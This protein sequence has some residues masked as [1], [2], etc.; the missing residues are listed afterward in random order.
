[1]APDALPDPIRVALDLAATFEHLRIPY[2]AV[3]SVAS[4]FHG[5]PRS[6]D[7]VD[8]VV[9]LTPATSVA[10]VAAL[11]GAFYVSADAAREAAATSRGGAFNVI[12]LATAVK[13]DLFVAGDDPFEA[14]RL[15]QRRRVRIAEDAPSDLYIDTAEHTI[16]RKLEWYRRGGAVSDRQW[17]DVV[18]IVR[19]Q[20]TRLDRDDLRVWADRLG[21]DDLLEQ[22]MR[23]GGVSPPR[24]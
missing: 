7:D 10:L 18:G 15:A 19:A 6:T 20:G 1:M 23:E 21:V 17:G 11:A 12:H 3:G 14:E 8:F 2:V 4:S 16:V 22:A 13:A 5:V 24:L 9:S